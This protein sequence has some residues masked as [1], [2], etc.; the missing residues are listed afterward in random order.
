M[1]IGW[2]FSFSLRTVPLSTMINQFPPRPP[3][4]MGV[5]STKWSLCDPWRFSLS[6]V[7]FDWRI[8]PL[9]LCLFFSLKVEWTY[10]NSLRIM[11]YRTASLSRWRIFL[12]ISFSAS[13]FRSRFRLPPAYLHVQDSGRKP[14]VLFLNVNFF[15]PPGNHGSSFFP[16]AG[17]SFRGRRG[18]FC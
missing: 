7:S 5:G 14:K 8:F 1:F 16:Y 11:F 4:Q 12:F 9:L 15:S 18:F 6:R 13:S 10:W 17:I 3:F 2:S